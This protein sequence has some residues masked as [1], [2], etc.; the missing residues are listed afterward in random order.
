MSAL[1]ESKYSISEYIEI[2]KKSDRRL[3]YFDGEIVA[4]SGGRLPHT[5]VT[6]NIPHFLDNLLEGSD[7]EVFNVEMAVKT[8]LWPPFRY[9]DASVACGK[10]QF[11]DMQ[12]IDVLLNPVLIV[13]GLSPSTAANDQDR[14][15][16]AYQ[17]IESFKE[18]LLVSQTRPHVT[19]YVRQS[20]GRW[21]RT[22]I[23]G[24]D[25]SVKLESVGVT[26]SFSEI[27]RRVN[28]Q[29]SGDADQ[30]DQL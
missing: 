24:M 16:V 30:K 15:F 23:I 17:A 26:L 7:C 21:L 9:P 28:F 14:K 29:P 20:D 5:R 11:E 1:P 3:E 27:Y 12:G 2:L 4:M 22:N 25:S 6:Q 8:D 13:E 18:Y 10:P 19:Q